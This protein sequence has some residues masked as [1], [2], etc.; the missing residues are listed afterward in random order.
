[1]ARKNIYT[2]A[3]N[4]TQLNIRNAPSA[5]FA[6]KVRGIEYRGSEVPLLNAGWVWTCVH[7]IRL[8]RAPGSRG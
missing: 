6:E 5:E 7:R 8:N 2:H 3:I 1:M 4:L